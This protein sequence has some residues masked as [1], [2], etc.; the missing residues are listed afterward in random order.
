[1]IGIFIFGFFI[2]AIVIA[3]CAL[4]VTGIREDQRSREALPEEQ[5]TTL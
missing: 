5:D 3:A 4:V 1:M 2:T